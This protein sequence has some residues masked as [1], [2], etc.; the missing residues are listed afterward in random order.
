MANLL[1]DIFILFKKS[2][3][4]P[5]TITRT[6]KILYIRKSGSNIEGPIKA[7]RGN[8]FRNWDLDSDNNNIADDDLGADPDLDIIAACDNTL[9]DVESIS[10]S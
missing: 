1:A 6:L 2:I 8:L 4:A 9:A 10:N 7:S 5:F 3:L